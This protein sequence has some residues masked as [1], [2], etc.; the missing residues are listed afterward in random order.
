M[1]KDKIYGLATCS[2]TK[3]VF[4]M[5]EQYVCSK[6]VGFFSFKNVHK[7]Y[8]FVMQTQ[9]QVNFPLFFL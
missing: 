5:L 9:F 2:W 7:K 6:F 8:I 1:S 3:F 4:L